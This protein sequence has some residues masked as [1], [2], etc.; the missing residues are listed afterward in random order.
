MIK[1]HIP[2]FIE[3][4]EVNDIL[5]YL[6]D[7]N[8]EYFYDDIC[9]SGIY[10]SFMP[11]IWNGGRILNG[12]YQDE[13]Y[14]KKYIDEYNDKNIGVIFTFTNTA[15]DIRLYADYICNN[16][17]KNMM[18]NLDINKIIIADEN[19]KQYISNSYSD[20]I[21]FILSTTSDIVIDSSVKEL[22]KHEAYYDLIVPNYN[23]NN[24]KALFNIKNPSKY[25]VMLN[26]QCVDHCK[27]EK[28]HYKSVSMINAEKMIFGNE[29]VCPYD[30]NGTYDIEIL[31]KKKT[32]I[33]VDDLYT[34]YKEKGFETFKINGRTGGM[35]TAVS[36]YMYYMVKPKYY[37]EVLKRFEDIIQEERLEELDTILNQISNEQSS[38]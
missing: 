36:Y 6:L 17:V 8:K 33:K 27:H 1:F 38:Q 14:R 18:D 3:N 9:I 23:H 37:S 13:T 29:F 21:K 35:D 15:L 28:E 31:S 22:E 5:I 26:P 4:K 34:K 25:E 20:K 19:L 11:C 32:F 7:N 10:G 30:A 2:G 16:D 24:T 12:M